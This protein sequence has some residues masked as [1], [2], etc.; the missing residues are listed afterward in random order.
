MKRQYT[1]KLGAVGATSNGVVHIN[2][3]VDS[4]PDSDRPLKLEADPAWVLEYAERLAEA[5]R[6][7]LAHT[8]A[9]K[10]DRTP[11]AHRKRP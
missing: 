6:R 8:E 4:G 5:A 10:A 1:F 2:G 7:T 3:Y 11:A 9:S